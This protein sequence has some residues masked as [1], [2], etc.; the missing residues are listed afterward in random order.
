MA[1]FTKKLVDQSALEALAQG[2]NKKAKDAVAAEKTRAEAAEKEAKDAATAAKTAA[3]GAQ[4]TA[5]EAKS[6]ADQAAVD[7]VKVKQ[8]IAD[9]NSAEGGVV[10]QAKEYTD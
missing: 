5:N 2:L 9:I 6:T 8:D 4:S 10:K 1:D 7:L 3:D